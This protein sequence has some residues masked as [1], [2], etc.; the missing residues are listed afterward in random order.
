MIQM[1]SPKKSVI[2]IEI[3]YF[4]KKDYKTLI[5]NGCLFAIFDTPCSLSKIYLPGHIIII[6][7]PITTPKKDFFI[8]G[9]SVILLDK[10]HS[11]KI[12]VVITDR[13]IQLGDCHQKISSPR[14]LNNSLLVINDEGTANSVIFIKNEILKMIA[15]NKKVRILRAILLIADYC[16]YKGTGA[17]Q[18]PYSQKLD[19]FKIAQPKFNL[20]NSEDN[21]FLPEPARLSPE[22]IDSD[23]EPEI[24]IENQD[25]SSSSYDSDLEFKSESEAKSSSS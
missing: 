24:P 19:F 16:M 1:V 9:K 3:D 7:A 20:T 5:A 18:I 22:K 15:I 8:S 12:S 10:I 21:D 4:P 25:E 11:H 2:S 23:E 14:K 13:W 6:L 17:K